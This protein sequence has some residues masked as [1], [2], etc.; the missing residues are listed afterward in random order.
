MGLKCQCDTRSTCK[1][2]GQCTP[3]GTCCCTRRFGGVNC[4]SCAAGRSGRDCADFTDQVADQILDYFDP[5]KPRAVILTE[6]NSKKQKF[7]PHLNFG[8]IGQAIANAA[9]KVSGSVT[10]KPQSKHELASAKLSDWDKLT[11][12]Q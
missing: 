7:F 6:V 2:G 1:N 3:M 5:S 12:K 8:N 11:C 9:N 10:K 4:E